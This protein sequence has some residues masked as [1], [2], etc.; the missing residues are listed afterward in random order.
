MMCKGHTRCEWGTADDAAA[1]LTDAE[2]DS[3]ICACFAC[4]MLH[5]QLC[6]LTLSPSSLSL[7]PPCF[8]R[9]VGHMDVRALDFQGERFDLIVDKGTLDAILCGDDSEVA[10][11]KSISEISR[12]LLPGGVFLMVSHAA[13]EYREPLLKVPSDGFIHYQYATVVKPRVDDSVD[14]KDD[15]VHYVYVAV[16]GKARK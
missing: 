13:P 3:N 7:S 8:L 16:K 6:I 1:Q 2:A 11:A 14:Q 9:S 12:V 5:S 4:L 15:E 10:A